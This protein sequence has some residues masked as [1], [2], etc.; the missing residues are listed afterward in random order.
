M[1]TQ[2]GDADI[3]AAKAIQPDIAEKFRGLGVQPH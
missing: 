2:P 3:A 1:E